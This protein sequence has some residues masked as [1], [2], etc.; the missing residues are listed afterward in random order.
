MIIEDDQGGLFGA[1]S[2][3]PL[4]NADARHKEFQSTQAAASR[5][6]R[7]GKEAPEPITAPPALPRDKLF[8]GDSTAFLFRLRKAPTAPDTPAEGDAPETWGS[9][10][11][12]A[13][14]VWFETSVFPEDQRGVGF[15]GRAELWALFLDRYFTMGSAYGHPISLTFNAPII[16]SSSRF[17][18]SRVEAW[19]CYEKSA[20]EPD[21]PVSDKQG[22]LHKLEE[23]PD[24]MIL[25]MQG[26]RFYSE[27]T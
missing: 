18:I 4:R 5:A 22:V 20:D 9:A 25:E 14:F 8:F 11:H 15:G 23:N 12:D 10:G 19:V 26:H 6:A 24:R 21:A 3:V 17:K 1:Y 16:A 7:L 27:E 2:G 13:N